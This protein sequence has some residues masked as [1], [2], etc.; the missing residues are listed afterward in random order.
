MAQG[1]I[2]VAITT[3]NRA[4]VFAESYIG[5]RQNMPADAAL[6][7]VDDGSDIPVPD[8]LGATV[9]RHETAQGIARAKNAGLKALMDLGC[10]HLFL[11]D[12]DIWP[13]FAHWWLPYVQSKHEHLSLSFEYKIDGSQLALD[14]RVTWRGQHTWVYESPNGCLLY[15]TRNVVET[16]GGYDP[17]FGRWG[18][19]HKNYSRRVHNFG[20]TEQPFMDVPDGATYFRILDR[21]GGVESSVPE[22]VRREHSTRNVK[23]YNKLQDEAYKVDL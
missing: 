18:M 7:V 19:E 20:L 9:I 4:D 1:K 21:E 12:D 10:D 15:M 14:V 5:W 23:L 22:S 6:V 11:A 13:A 16:V 2:G 3:H 17:R 8:V